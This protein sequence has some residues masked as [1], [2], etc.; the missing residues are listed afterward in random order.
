MKKLLL[1]FITLI[2]LAV[3]CGGSKQNGDDVAPEE[4]ANTSFVNI[5][6]GLTKCYDKG[7]EIN[8]PKDGKDFYGQDANYAKLKK[9]VPRQFSIDSSVKNEPVVIDKSTGLKWQQSFF[10]VENSAE[11]SDYCENLNY[12]GNDDWRVPTVKELFS[13]IDWSRHDPAINT[14]YFHG[15]PSDN[16]LASSV[17][18]DYVWIIDFSK[19]E[20]FQTR[21][22][23]NKLYVRCVRGNDSF[24]NIKISAD[25]GSPTVYY[26][27]YKYRNFNKKSDIF[28]EEKYGN[29]VPTWEEALDF[30]Q[31]QTFAGVSWRLPNINELAFFLFH[32]GG[33]SSYWS[34]T[35]Y[36]EDPSGAWI[37]KFGSR[38]TAALK[39][40]VQE[41]FVVSCVADAP[42]ENGLAWTG[43]ECENFCKLNPCKSMDLSNGKC[44]LNYDNKLRKDS[45]ICGCNQEEGALWDDS[46][47]I[48]VSPCDPNPCEGLK[49]ATGECIVD[50][51][52]GMWNHSITCVC[53]VN[54]YWWN[55]RKCTNECEGNPCQ[56]EEHAIA[57]SC[58]L[59]D[60]STGYKCN[61]EEG[62][63]W[64]DFGCEKD[65]EEN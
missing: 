36:A 51:W 13:I 63:Y 42:C 44:E 60:T 27:D 2:F 45:F 54:Y 47:K 61:C 30:C 20:T 49:H 25:Y 56:Y 59:V 18:K 62:Y 53:D 4:D 10:E 28:L 35:T 33:G 52:N 1:F 6:T 26:I 16:F 37:F 8:C 23:G 3:S 40:G 29:G 11:A 12:S 24:W 32:I 7:K 19:G 48:C 14:D 15:T 21:D 65:S 57:D 9:C 58:S 17:R 34:S 38:V 31:K 22:A 64:T 46:Q 55:G 43:T 39:E 41:D 5:C 50:E